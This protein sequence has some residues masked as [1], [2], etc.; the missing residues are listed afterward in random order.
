MADGS[1]EKNGVRAQHI[2]YGKLLNCS[3]KTNSRISQFKKKRT[4]IFLPYHI[5][6]YFKK[7]DPVK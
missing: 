3:C 5:F 1:H 7:D 2:G 6:F 4:P